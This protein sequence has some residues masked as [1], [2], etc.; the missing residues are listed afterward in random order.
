MALKNIF[1]GCRYAECRCAIVPPMASTL[2]V[3]GIFAFIFAPKL[4][5]CE[6]LSSDEQISDK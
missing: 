4:G 1:A 3:Y 2:I 6:C 5:K